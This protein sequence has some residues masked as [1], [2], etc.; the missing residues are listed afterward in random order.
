MGNAMQL[1]HPRVSIEHYMQGNEP[2]I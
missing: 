2:G 1:P